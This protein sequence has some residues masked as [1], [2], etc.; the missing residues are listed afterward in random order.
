[1][2]DFWNSPD[3][4]EKLGLQLLLKQNSTT[5][6]FYKYKKIFPNKS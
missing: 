4:F 1:M 3:T 5:E 6:V 2:E